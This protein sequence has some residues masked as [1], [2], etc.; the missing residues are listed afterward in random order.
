MI[1]PIKSAVVM[2]A[3]GNT[4]ENILLQSDDQ[5]GFK[6]IRPTS[7]AECSPCYGT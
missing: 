2:F 4:L 6:S 7:L 3:L 5:D 1:V